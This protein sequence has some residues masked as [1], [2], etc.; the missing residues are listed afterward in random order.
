[1]GASI[2]YGFYTML[3]IRI[4]SISLMR[5]TSDTKCRAEFFRRSMEWFGDWGY[6]QVYGPI[7]TIM[8]KK[9][10]G[11]AHPKYAFSRYLRIKRGKINA[12]NE[13]LMCN[14]VYIS[15]LMGRS[16]ALKTGDK[17]STLNKI[18]AR[19]KPAANLN[20]EFSRN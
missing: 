12:F 10:R 6:N 8:G 18:W 3:A 2:S 20:P 13:K 1:M 7:T 4:F 9:C 5:N 19:M 14:W 17:Q 16:R 11:Q 15:P